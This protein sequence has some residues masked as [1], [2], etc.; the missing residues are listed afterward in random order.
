MALP[1]PI[2]YAIDAAG[3]IT[4][5]VQWGLDGPIVLFLHGLGSSA[6]IWN[7]VAPGIAANGY[8]CVAVDSPGHG[9]S[10]KGAGFSYDLAGHLRWLL[11]ILDTL[12]ARDV[13]L[14]ASSLGGL[15]ATG[16]AT[17]H[18]HRLRSL[19][20]IG[21]IG[22]AKL[23]DDRRQWTASYLAQMDRNSVAARLR[24]A[25]SDPGLVED[26]RVEQTFRMNNSPGA[27]DAFSAIGS[28]YLAGLNED[29]QI[30]QLVALRRSWP[31]L[32]IWGR[33]D[34]IVPYEQAVA[35]S[36]RIPGCTLLALDATRHVPHIERPI[37]VCWALTR[38]LSGQ[39][40]SSGPVEGGEVSVPARH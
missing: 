39:G 14:V 34:T 22:L 24:A 25:L 2:T 11:A 10:G 1:K 17:H 37:I 27:A 16:F 33:Q 19:A 8:R 30:E 3:L 12:G 6:D 20:L 32:L 31:V 36:F 35:A 5:V 9:L 13:H 7:E 38:H 28:Y 23:P 21:G 26:A 15:W 40:L 29:I 4:R 18:P